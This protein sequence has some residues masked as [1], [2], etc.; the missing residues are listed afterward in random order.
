MASLSPGEAR[1]PS[2]G[3]WPVAGRPFFFCLTDIAFFAEAYLTQN[4]TREAQVGS[5]ICE[6]VMNIKDDLLTLR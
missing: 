4:P 3:V 6:V 2:R 5:E 1:K